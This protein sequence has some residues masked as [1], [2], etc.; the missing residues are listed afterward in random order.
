[1][2]KIQ[3][4]LFH[5]LFKISG[6]TWGR[7]GCNRLAHCGQ[8]AHGVH[9][10]PL[11]PPNGHTSMR[12]ICCASHDNHLCV[13]LEGVP[14]KLGAVGLAN[15]RQITSVCLSTCSREYL[16]N[17]MN[18]QQGKLADGLSFTSIVWTRFAPRRRWPGNN[19]R[20]DSKFR[21]KQSVD[22]LES[23]R[24]EITTHGAATSMFL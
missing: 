20:T 7:I 16:Y 5:D 22:S 10:S 15:R 1:M 14:V 2:A 19:G 24:A 4:V 17:T 6:S 23:Y 21:L 11:L 9:I 3:L 18:R 12:A 8:T 13:Q